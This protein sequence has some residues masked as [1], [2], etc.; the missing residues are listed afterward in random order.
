MTGDLEALKDGVSAL[1]L[2]AWQHGEVCDL[3]DRATAAAAGPLKAEIASLRAERDE[4]AGKFASAMA[5]LRDVQAD[6]DHY[7]DERDALRE[8]A[9]AYLTELGAARAELAKAEVPPERRRS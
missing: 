5:M 3:V 1:A 6:R 9:A 7:R 2:S 8:R 4:Y